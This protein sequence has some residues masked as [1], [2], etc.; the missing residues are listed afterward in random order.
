MRYY[1]KICDIY[2]GDDSWIY[3]YDHETKQ[4]SSE[5]VF[6]DEPN[7]T[8]V[9]RVKS[10]LMQMVTCFF[11]INGHKSEEIRKNNR[12][13][14][15][16]LHYDNGSCHTSAKTTRILEGQK[17]ELMSHPLYSP[18]LSPNDYY[19]ILSVKNKLRGQFFEPRRDC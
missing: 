15:I 3:A 1:L 6:Y 10:T 5:W 12:E 19:L 4:Q 17:T 9:I 8:N 14:R 7:P 11:G 2:I 18:D 16:I 13:R